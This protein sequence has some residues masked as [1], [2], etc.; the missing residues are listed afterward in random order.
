[1]WSHYKQSFI[2]VQTFSLVVGWMLYRNTTPLW[3]PAVVFFL[4][5]QVS[6][7]LGA[8]WANQLRNETRTSLPTMLN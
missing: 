4:S 2:A 8:M 6:S 3:T 7:L 5:M 1:M